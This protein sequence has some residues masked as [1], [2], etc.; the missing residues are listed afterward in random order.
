MN[1]ILKIVEPDKKDSYHG[2][3]YHVYFEY[4]PEQPVAMYKD[5]LDL[6]KFEWLMVLAGITE[7]FIEKHRE[8]VA[9]HARMEGYRD[10][11][12]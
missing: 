1:K 3:L 10:G 4:S 9:D 6:L 12:Y 11:C 5:R 7:E 8:L 2:G